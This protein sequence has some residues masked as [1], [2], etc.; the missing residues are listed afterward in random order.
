M[1]NKGEA[2]GSWNGR[3]SVRRHPLAVRVTHWLNVLCMTVLLLSGLQ[4][5]NAH[6]ALYWGEASDFERPVFAMTAQDRGADGLVGVTS[7]LG[8]PLVTT[9]V[10]GVSASADGTPVARGVPAVLTLPAG[11]DL[12]SGRRWHFFFGWVFVLNGI[13]YLSYAL[14]SGHAQKRLL[15]VASEL[16]SIPRTAW[17]HLRFRFPKG[18][19]ARRYNVLQKIAYLGVILVLLPTVIL[20]GLTMSPAMNAAVPEFLTLFGGRQSARTIHFLAAAALV[21]FVV[22]HVG[23]VVVSGCW[24]NMRFMITGRYVVDLREESR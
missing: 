13:A 8:R 9:G 21:G 16:K 12:A 2:T 23:L 15:P 4:I 17:E 7:V 11:Q 3:V 19:E 22:V 14:A 10:L 24:N 20:T 1:F 5:F 18:E 6:P